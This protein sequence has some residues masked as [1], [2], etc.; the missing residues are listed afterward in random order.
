M[1]QRMKKEPA[2][3]F[4]AVLLTSVSNSRSG[5][6]HK[7]VSDILSDVDRLDEYSAVKINFVEAGL[8]KAD[9][10]SAVH[11]GAKKRKLAVLTTSDDCHLYVFRGP[12]AIKTRR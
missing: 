4:P 7:I 11:R 6:H 9:L 8:K 12:A 3:Y 1:A 2:L 5:K 10:R